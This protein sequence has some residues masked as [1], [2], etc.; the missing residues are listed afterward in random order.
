VQHLYLLTGLRESGRVC[1][2]CG[3]LAVGSS[4]SCPACGGETRPTELVE[5]I[6]DRVIASGGSVATLA[7]HPG[8]ERAGGLA[9]RL[10]YSP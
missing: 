7:A 1:R 4:G 10:R 5:A 3:M 6:V 2:A 8:L 9:A